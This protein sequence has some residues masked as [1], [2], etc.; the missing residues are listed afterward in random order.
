MAYEYDQ[1][2]NVIGEYESEEER[3]RRMDAEQAQT[4][5]KQTIT[6]NPDGTQEMTIKGTPQALS[7]MN[8][9]TP[10]VSGPVPPDDTFKRMQQIES[11][12]RDFD[13][14]G[15]PI[16]SP[17][18][19]MYRNQVM[20]A[21]ARDPGYGIT[22]A[23]DESPEEYNR[24]G[25]EYYQ[26]M[27]KK[28]GGD[29]AAAAAAYNAGPGRVERNMQANA[30]TMNVGQLP[31]ETQ[32]YLQKLGN[33]VGSV[34]P[35]A[36]AKTVPQAP[37]NVGSSGFE[38][39]DRNRPGA[40]AFQGGQPTYDR[41]RPGA[42]PFEGGAQPQTRP[43]NT[44]EQAA[45]QQ[46]NAGVQ[47]QL[48]LPDDPYQQYL[49]LPDSPK[50]RLAY[51]YDPNT[52][53]NLSKHIKK[54]VSMKLAQESGLV[55][56]EE[57]V[58]TMDENAVAKA[59]REKTTGGSYIKAILFG[60]L[61]M[62]RSAMAEAAKLGIGN[63][64]MAL[65]GNEPVMVK[66]AANGT[67]ISGINSK[68]GK[69]LT[70]QELIAATQ[71]A[72]AVK[73]TEV[74]AGTYMDPTGKVAGNWVLE[75]RP[76]G[77]VYRQVG[78]GSIASPEQANALRKVG[79][80]GTLS[81]QRAKIIQEAQIKAVGKTNEQAQKILE[82][83]NTL[84]AGQG[85]P[86]I[87]P[88]E[89]GLQGPDFGT[90]PGVPAVGGAPAA[91]PTAAAAAP[92]AATAAPTAATAPTAL[93]AAAPA[94][95][96]TVAPARTFTPAMVN[97]VLASGKRPTMDELKAAQI[98]AEKAAIETGTDMGKLKA[99]LN[100]KE[101]VENTAIANINRIINAPGFE[102][103]GSKIG[104]FEYGFGLKDKPFEGTKAFT[105][106]KEMDRFK[107][108]TFLQQY[109]ILRGGG[110]I[111]ESEGKQ[112]VDGYT[113]LNSG[114]PKED[115]IREALRTQNQFKI[116]ANNDRLKLGMEP[117]YTQVFTDEQF[118]TMDIKAKD[119]K[120]YYKIDGNWY[121]AGK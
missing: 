2:G 47:G 92:T 106:E 28:F 96:A 91:A 90:A 38:P 62:E 22:P 52:P 102:N 79:V 98:Y 44:A 24:V 55:L 59:L 4:P 118:N 74:E 97:T 33:V 13:A 14:Q 5:V 37:A 67:P 35:S 48:N 119:N 65:L 53:E 30:G 113:S 93:P 99:N 70:A 36:E 120:Y 61:G 121:Q 80:S 40:A 26:A 104:E 84:L 46:A 66:V 94:A 63:E 77:S 54:Q 76:G 75:R 18:G 82:P 31:Q 100:N 20:P 88:S 23:R 56:A 107:G 111:T 87:Q 19:A 85:L 95:A 25:Q 16:Q 3:K 101:N 110:Q 73:G 114:M 117:K 103:V 8:P 1:L 89:L 43:E 7:P 105:F 50:D 57:Q 69:E 41:N 27:L 49:N 6:T 109:N 34:I 15:R 17:A 11:G 29:K 86:I 116:V 39:Y 64:T 12:N 32:G 9:N 60:L 72:Q 71:G 21:T 112:A 81:D 115:F 10:T 83:Y 51:A 108:A 68:T 45:F 42:A 58:K 78:T